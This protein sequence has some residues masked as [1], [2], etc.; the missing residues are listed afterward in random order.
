MLGRGG[1]LFL[2]KVPA[3]QTDLAE[4]P[5]LRRRA[6][7]L[8]LA[9]RVQRGLRFAALVGE[10]AE[11][12]PCVERR[13]AERYRKLAV[14]LCGVDVSQPMEDLRFQKRQLPLG[15]GNLHRHIDAGFG[16]FKIA[17]FEIN[18]REAAKKHGITGLDF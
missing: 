17:K 7:I 3:R 1:A 15:R 9:K 18:L 11:L 2:Q 12:I 8:C 13:F 10:P 14:F 6:Q 16:P 5:S 4:V